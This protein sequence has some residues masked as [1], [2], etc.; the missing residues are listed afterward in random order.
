MLWQYRHDGF[1]ASE[2][3]MSSDLRGNCPQGESTPALT[4]RLVGP[5]PSAA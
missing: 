3:G 5:E 4:A 1:E 2:K